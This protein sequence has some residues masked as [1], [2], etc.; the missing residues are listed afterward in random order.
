[1]TTPS[2]G[3]EQ[4]SKSYYD[5]FSQTYEKQRHHGYHVLIDDL[6]L[7]AAAPHVGAGPVLEAGCGTGLILRRL[8]QLNL[9]QATVGIDLSAGMLQVARSRGLRIAQ[10]S[11]DALPFPDDSFDTVVSFKVLAHVPEIQRALVELG[12]V[13]RPG[14]H[15]LLEFYNRH[16]LRTLIKRLKRPSRIGS[17]FND[18][19]VFT[20]F[21]SLG[22]IR[23]YLPP[24]LELVGTR[25]VRVV[26]PL[27][28]LHDFPLLGKLLGA[29]ERAAGRTPLLRRLAGFLIVVLRKR[30][31]DGQR[32][33]QQ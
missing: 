11:V 30:P 32:P 28:Q 7:E 24:E 23:G 29:A 16:S 31:V 14:G 22:Q 10:A 2:N 4:R 27:A 18:E 17:R 12:R 33:A 8:Q 6:E 21:D 25:G 26:T 3:S 9:G 20:R 1:M 15:L 19:D 5:E 13:T